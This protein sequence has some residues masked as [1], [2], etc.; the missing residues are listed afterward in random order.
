MFDR[1]DQLVHTGD[2]A[3]AVHQLRRLLV[4]HPALQPAYARLAELTGEADIFEHAAALAPGS[5]HAALVAGHALQRAGRL[6]A[7]GVKTFS[8]CFQGQIHTFW[9]F[10]LMIKGAKPALEEFGSLL[11]QAL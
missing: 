6:E 8:K 1:I 3:A 11:R 7:A 10:P 5:A 4:L 9:N 2:P